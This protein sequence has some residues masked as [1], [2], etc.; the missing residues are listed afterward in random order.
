MRLRS[1]I[2]A[3]LGAL[4]TLS[5]ALAGDFA[6]V[7]PQPTGE[8][9]SPTPIGDTMRSL[10]I[11]ELRLGPALTNL[12]LDPKVHLVNGFH[13]LPDPSSLGKGRLEGAAFEV[14]FRTP[15][16][17]AL[18]WLGSPRPSLGG[19]LNLGGHESFVHAGLDWHVPLGATPFYLEGG[20]G[21]GT[22]NGYLDNA[23]PGFHD[24]G[25]RVLLHFKYAAGWNLNDH[26]TVTLQ[27]QHMSNM[28]FGC[29]ANQGLNDLGLEVGWKF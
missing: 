24:L 27:W 19:V 3:A 13:P 11:S 7:A 26:T 2:G 22:H 12:E 17:G 29:G 21:V 15:E 18:A 23:P 25:C 8:V 10:G 20:L 1:V 14:L 4:L 9:L 5:P 16:I 6:F 28:V